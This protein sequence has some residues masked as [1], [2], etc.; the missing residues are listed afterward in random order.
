MS[1]A[2]VGPIALDGDP[3]K[4]LL[5]LQERLVIAEEQAI[6]D[7]VQEVKACHGRQDYPR[8]GKSL[9][10]LLDFLTIGLL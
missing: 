1:F 3:L 7:V 10:F 8:R 2:A 5:Q 4:D 9:Y 6:M